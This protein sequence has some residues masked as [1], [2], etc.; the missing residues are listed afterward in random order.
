MDE[1]NLENNS[2]N[3]G[4][5]PRKHNSMRILLAII[6][7]NLPTLLLAQVEATSEVYNFDIRSRDQS[8]AELDWLSNVDDVISYREKS[9]VLK[10]GISCPSL[11]TD[12]QILINGVNLNDTRGLGVVKRRTTGEYDELI[13]VPIDLV[14]GENK[15]QVSITNKYMKETSEVRTVVYTPSN[16]TRID[17]ALIFATDNYE[18]WDDLSNPIF[19]AKTI[20]TE[21]TDQYG[22]EVEL[23]TDNTI[24]D[25][26][27]K[28]K[29]YAGKYYNKNDQLF[30]FFAGHGHYD[31]LLGDGYIVGTESL[32]NDPTNKT[33]LSYSILA[34]ALNNIPANHI[35]LTMDVCFGGTFDSK[36]ASGDRGGGDIYSEVSREEFVARRLKYKTRKFL[37]SGGV[38]YVPDGRPGEHSPFT[39]RFIAALRSQGGDDRILTLSDI[40]DNVSRVNPQPHF[41]EFGSNEAGSDFI[42]MAK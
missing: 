24:D 4:D 38:Q 31:E 20:S 29:E 27:L 23:L 36:L 37:T 8:P 25:I 32:V 18:E 12:S 22:Y 3:S 14:P 16:S 19:D 28:L 21:L 13:E 5:L 15:I 40:L 35:F 2:T 30:V 9:F 11:I 26:L 1:H 17:R 6:L 39:K 10:V 33:Y 7:I 34:R 41:G 42:F